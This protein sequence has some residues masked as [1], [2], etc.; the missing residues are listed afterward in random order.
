MNKYQNR[1]NLFKVLVGGICMS[2][3]L[4][5]FGIT[6]TTLSIAD[7][8]TNN[9]EI[10]DLQTEI[11]EL[12]IEYF[13]RVNSLSMDEAFNLGMEEEDDILYAR[14]DEVKSVAYNL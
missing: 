9:K 5:G 8:K 13:E 6:G 11:A 7:A 3:V 1:K 2:F 4:Y 14:I 10:V 12:E